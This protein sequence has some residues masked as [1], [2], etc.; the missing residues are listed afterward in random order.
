MPLPF[1]RKLG[2]STI[3]LDPISGI[4]GDV[5]VTPWTVKEFE[6]LG[7]ELD[8]VKTDENGFDSIKKLVITRL[9]NPDGSPS[10]ATVADLDELEAPTLTELFHQILTRCGFAKREDIA[11]N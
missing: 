2:R 10:D 4:E 11:K 8:R 3:K 9:V 5:H 6:D 1:R 7:A